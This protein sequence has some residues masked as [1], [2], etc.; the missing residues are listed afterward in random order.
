MA[1]FNELIDDV[2]MS[3]HGYSMQQEAVTYIPNAITDT[4]TTVTLASVD[5]VGMGMIEI[6]DELLYVASVNRPA[7]AVVIP[8]FGRGYMSSTAASHEAGSKVT[9]AP[10]Y[11]RKMIKLAINDTIRGL[12][13]SIYA[14][15]STTFFYNGVQKEFE[16]PSEAERI[17]AVSVESDGPSKEWY[18]VRYWTVSRTAPVSAFP[19]GRTITFGDRVST[20]ENINVFYS[21]IPGELSSGTD[22]FETATGLPASCRDLVT[23]GATYRLLSMVDPGRLNYSN[24][25]SDFQAGRVNFGSGTNTAKYV[26]ALYQQRF[27]E[28]AAK[29]DS[30]HPVRVHFV[31]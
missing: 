10:L 12:F 21:K 7:S 8:P 1:T 25:E 27:A 6:D 18:P 28:E 23:L 4:D 29:L 31:R 3:L 2:A 17:I 20:M 30:K 22:D 19:S 5:N 24:P 26:Y 11:P 16:I 14:T 13:P 15:G 9:I